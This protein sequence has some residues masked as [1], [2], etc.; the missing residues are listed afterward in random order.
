MKNIK[1]LDC[2]FRDGGYYNNWKFTYSQLNEYIQKIS[3]SKID[4]I[5][6]GFRFFEKN[7]LFGPFAYSKENFLSK[8]FILLIHIFLIKRLK[9]V[10]N[11]LK[12]Q[13]MWLII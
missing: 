1:L 7:K 2:S 8:I 12:Q 10:V 5:E 11:I 3:N 13:K 6:I 4:V 9:T